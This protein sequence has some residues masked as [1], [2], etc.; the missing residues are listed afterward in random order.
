MEMWEVIRLR[1]ELHPGNVGGRFGRIPPHSRAKFHPGEGAP[2]RV[3]TCAL[4]GHSCTVQGCAKK[5]APG[6]EKSSASLQ[7][8]QGGHARLV[9]NKTFTFLHTTLYFVWVAGHCN[10]HS[11]NKVNWTNL[12]EQMVNWTKLDCPNG[13]LNKLLLTKIRFPKSHFEHISSWTN[14]NITMAY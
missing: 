7:P 9:L 10:N 14:S 13:H 6:W 8:A 12:N 4:Q 3:R 1:D 5:L 11:L 2:G